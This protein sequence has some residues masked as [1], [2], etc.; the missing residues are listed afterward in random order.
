MQD[1]KFQAFLAERGHKITAARKEV[2]TTLQA[3]GTPLTNAE[4][5]TLLNG[6]VD[7][8]SVYRVLELFEAIGVTH[9]LWNGF[10][11]KSEL[12]DAFSPHHHH[13]TC[14][15]CGKIESF[16]DEAIEAAL[17]RLEQ[18]RGI[19]ITSH[20]IELTGYCE[21]CARQPASST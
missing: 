2:F 11:S 14:R 18:M 13:F 9:R 6:V 21:H 16:K 20:L 12:T 7:K 17:Q 10:K 5:I 4:I 15:R 3:A 8:T 1:E 19:D